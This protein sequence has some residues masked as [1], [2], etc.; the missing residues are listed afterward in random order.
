MGSSFVQR[1]MESFATVIP[2]L[3]TPSANANRISI[4]KDITPSTD[5]PVE[6]VMRQAQTRQKG[7]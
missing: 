7:L 6:N 3:D 2:T 5:E 4:E 1:M